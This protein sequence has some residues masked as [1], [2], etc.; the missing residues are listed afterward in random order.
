MPP[1]GQ[2][3]H[4]R[5]LIVGTL[6]GAVVA[7]ACAGGVTA[8]PSAGPGSAVVDLS[9]HA[10]GTTSSGGEDEDRAGLQTT[11]DRVAEAF[12]AAD[13]ARL[14]SHLHDPD[15]G[16][17]RRWLAR[18][19]RLA[20]V[21]LASYA[22]ELDPSLPD[23][24]TEDVRSRYDRPVLVV[25]V[26]EEHALEGYD[27]RGRLTSD[28]FLT[29]VRT[30]DGWKVAGDTDGEPLGLVSA[31]HLWDQGPVATTRSGPLLALHHPGMPGIAAVLAEARAALDE[32]RSRW[33]L[34]WPERVPIV[35]PRDQEE[36]GELLHATFDLSSF[37]AFATGSPRGRLGEFELT[38]AR[39]VV[40]PDRFL[41]RSS[42]SRRSILAHELLHVATRPVS[43]PFVPSWVEEGL[44]QRL[45]D[46]RST[47]GLGLLGDL[48]AGGT[49]SGQL[50]DDSQFVTGGQQRIFLSY[51]LAFSFVDHLVD[52]FGVETVARFYRELGR[53][54]VGEPG[55]ER[56]HV[57]RAA[58][59]VLGAP[60]DELR[61]GWRES[62]AGG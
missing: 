26:R 23:L 22:L 47:T 51:Q 10:P 2:R 55:R 61:A 44:A 53:G 5:R 49:F 31:D 54:S 1:R 13:P 38:G 11:L 39:I 56:W 28:L 42:S 57:D 27:R 59:T 4:R 14:R 58:R 52:R 37:V 41:N 20:D 24:S 6:L 12:A 50:P 40:N 3:A 30:P 33:P 7:S 60:L 17:G 32:V 8:P 46:Q 48:V 62:L 15:S 29:V 36:L 18:A 21:P 34:E 19:E 45:G 35:V 43:G 25:Y 9:G 16:F